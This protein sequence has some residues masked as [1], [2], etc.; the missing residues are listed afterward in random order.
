[1]EG[2]T[3]GTPAT[4]RSL[5]EMALAV[6]LVFAGELAQLCGSTVWNE[7]RGIVGERFRTIYAVRYGSYQQ[8][9]LAAM[10]ATGA[11][12]FSDII[13]P[14]LSERDQQT[15]LRTYRLWPDIRVSSF[16][17]NWRDQVRGWSDKARADFVSELLHH[18]NDGEVANFAAEDNSVA[19]KKAAASG[20][21]WN[22]SE[23]A[24]TRVL[25]SMDV[26]TFEDVAR[27]N[28]NLMPTAL[29]SKTVAVMRRFIETSTD[30]S[31]RLRTALDLVELGETGLDSVLKHAITAL[32]GDDM[33]KLAHV[34]TVA[35]R[36]KITGGAR[37]AAAAHPLNVRADECH[38]IRQVFG[39]SDLCD[40]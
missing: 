25:E 38:E 17:S 37:G 3:R 30:H 29:R 28:A 7:V 12:D 5:V 1:M 14:L 33:R 19:V 15:R 16:G 24:L 39:F 31:A 22:K 6:D 20:L 27:K 11:D 10:L 35:E 13:V 40:R 34:A 18:R 8:Y 21:M 4:E 2:P 9:A 36:S 26:Q 32:P 23:D